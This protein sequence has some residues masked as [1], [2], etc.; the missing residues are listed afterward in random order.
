MSD[1]DNP[2][3]NPVS[4]A[5]PLSPAEEKQWA[6]LAHVLG[7]FFGIITAA[8]FF[9]LYKDRGPFVRSH[10]VAEWNFRLTI[11]IVAGVIGLFAV[12]GWAIAFATALSGPE[13]S[14]GMA[15]SGI[16]MFLIGLLP[17]LHSFGTIGLSFG[18]LDN[19]K[20]FENILCPMVQGVFPVN[21]LGNLIRIGAA[22]NHF[23]DAFEG[24]PRSSIPGTVVDGAR[25]YGATGRRTS[26]IPFG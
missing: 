21:V 8:V 17:I 5:P 14:S 20:V 22:G 6:V 11:A 15:L 19:L 12:S 3:A 7:I 25:L 16:V 13:A 18:F 10:V 2:Y 23:H 4:V 1:I 9:F 24:P 26:D